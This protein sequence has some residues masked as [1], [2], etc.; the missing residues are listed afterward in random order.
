M[1]HHH[2]QNM[3]VNPT[4]YPDTPNCV[5]Q[6]AN[7]SWLRTT[8]VKY[9]INGGNL[10]PSLTKNVP[11]V[12][13]HAMGYK[14]IPVCGVVDYVITDAMDRKYSVILGL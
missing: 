6:T 4:I 10:P 12:H 11:F 7:I 2:P 14:I 5:N 13:R 1:R 8:P 3:Q 9:T